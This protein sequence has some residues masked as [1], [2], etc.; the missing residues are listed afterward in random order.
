MLQ[1]S[2]FERHPTITASVIVCFII[3]LLYALFSWRFIRNEFTEH[4]KKSVKNI[5]RERLVVNIVE[6]DIGRF[7]V[8][9]EYKPNSVLFERPTRELMSHVAPNTITRK[10]YR[11]S[12]DRHGFIGPSEIYPQADKKILFLGGSTTECLYVDEEQRFVYLVGR[13][14]EQLS[15]KKIH[16]YNGGK[17]ANESHHSLNHFLN[18]G[19]GIEPDIAVMMHNINDLV[20]LRLQGTYAYEDSRLSHVQNSRTV[21]TIN[22]YP[23]KPHAKTDAQLKAAF[24]R[25]LQTFIE[26]CHIHQVTP[27]LMTQA[28]RVTDDALYHEFNQVI[29]DI[30]HR[31]AVKLIDLAE[32]VP[33]K[34]ELIYDSYHYSEQGSKLAAQIITAALKDLV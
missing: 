21:L 22:G 33:A 11:V 2:L 30:A 28:N 17:S 19:L 20:M 27:V 7:I 16:A 26:V 12:T 31:S 13:Q 6:Q 34:P 8:L 1:P 15:G 24:A 10:Y 32:L 3:S 5:L 18:K 9:R 4:E 25:N 14:L 29:R 23:A